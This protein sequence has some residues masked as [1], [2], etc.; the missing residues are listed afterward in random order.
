MLTDEEIIDALV[1]RNHDAVEIQS[2]W[3]RLKEK[4]NKIPCP[5]FFNSTDGVH[6][7][8]INRCN[9]PDADK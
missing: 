1:Y 5:H 6:C 3:S 7:V 2:A 8:L 4:I 9:H